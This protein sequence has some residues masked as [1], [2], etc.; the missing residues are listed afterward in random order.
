MKKVTF[1]LDGVVIPNVEKSCELYGIDFD[2]ITTYRID[3]CELLTEE[4]K[5]QIKFGFG[6]VDAFIYSG[7]SQGAEH[8]EKLAQNCILHINSLSCNNDIKEY[9]RE[10]LKMLIPSLLEENLTLGVYS[11]FIV[12][13]I[14]KTDIVVEDCLENLVENYDTFEKAYL[15]DHLYNRDRDLSQ[16]PKIVRVNDLE[17]CI[18]KI[19]NEDLV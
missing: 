15:I 12:K 2:K 4:E 10:L 17:H 1:D 19:L 8:L 11:D 3:S 9:K 16:Y 18:D 7:V 14:E 6:S 5:R 13:E